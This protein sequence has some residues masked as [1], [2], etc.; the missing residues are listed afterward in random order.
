MSKDVFQDNSYQFFLNIAMPGGILLQNGVYYVVLL[1]YCI[2]CCIA[3]SGHD[4]SSDFLKSK[5]TQHNS[6]SSRLLLLHRDGYLTARHLVTGDFL[7]EAN[8]FGPIFDEDIR[9]APDAVTEREDPFAVPFFIHGSSLY[10]FIPSRTHCGRGGGEERDR[11]GGVSEDCASPLGTSPK[12]RRRFFAN[13]S[14]LLQNREFQYNGTDFHVTSDVTILDINKHT[15][16]VVDSLSPPVMSDPLEKP[17]LLLQ[18]PPLDTLSEESFLHVV[19]HNI[20]LTAYKTNRYKWILSFAQLQI[21]ERQQCVAPQKLEKEMNSPVGD[22]PSRFLALLN[23]FTSD[24]R[25]LTAL[26][27]VS[28]SL[29]VREENSTHISLWNESAQ[30]HVWYAPVL[31]HEHD[32]LLS[33][34]MVSPS[35]RVAAAWLVSEEG[36]T[37]LPFVPHEGEIK[38]L[39]SSEDFDVEAAQSRGLLPSITNFRIHLPVYGNRLQDLDNEDWE[40]EKSFSSYFPFKDVVWIERDM[41]F[42]LF[43]HLAFFILSSLLMA[44]GILPREALMVARP[45]FHA[46]YAWKM[47]SDQ[48]ACRQDCCHIGTGTSDAVVKDDSHDQSYD[49]IS[50]ITRRS[51]SPYMLEPYEEVR[52]VTGG[53]GTRTTSTSSMND[54]MSLSG[55]VSQDNKLFQEMFAIQEKIGAGG[56]GSIF[57]VTHKMTHTPYAIKAVPIRGEAKSVV[58]EA[59]LH[60]RFDH[61]H[62]VR[63]NFCWIEDITAEDAAKYQLF[64]RDDGLDSISWEGDST[65]DSRSLSTDLE[66]RDSSSGVFRTLFILMEY[67]EKGTLSN[68]LETRKKMDRFENLLHVKSIAMGLHYLHQRNVVHRDLK[69]TN[70]FVTTHNDLKIGDFGL[71]KRRENA[72]VRPEAAGVQRSDVNDSSSAG[73]G[74]P[75]YSSPEQLSLLP[76]TKASDMFSLG[77]IIVELYSNFT[78]FHER[79]DVF[80]KARGGVLPDVFSHHYPQEAVLVLQMLRANPEERPT[81]KEVA[82]QF[83][84]LIA[85]LRSEGRE[86]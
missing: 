75:L 55:G 29:V 61:P 28:P 46:A 66:S 53:M 39:L 23:A 41:G 57:L 38:R 26:A 83:A 22:P 65:L 70:I 14:D 27:G 35:R 74:S 69:P 34:M 21:S 51:E 77:L 85:K 60:S 31:S 12:L 15:G 54:E 19:R 79:S 84:T 81:A 71:A 73:W 16:G 11:S 10:S 49:E 62:V 8:T 24:K 43:F 37:P 18:G 33:H 17:L 13:I 48:L 80:T 56:E 32:S 72:S 9:M 20:H 6:A 76:A 4:L 7:W 50:D 47:S 63:Y 2:H 82:N 3:V 52:R 44:R 45:V 5:P 64:D 42:L 30:A 36:I 68:R 78:T 40:D 86:S 59:M 67:F 25:D 1:L 58:K